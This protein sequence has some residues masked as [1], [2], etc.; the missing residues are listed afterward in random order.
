M[1]GNH[2]NSPTTQEPIPWDLAKL[3][4]APK[5]VPADGYSDPVAHAVFID[6]LPYQGRPTRFFA[7][8]AVPNAKDGKRV[9]G[10]VLVHGGGGTAH[11]RWVKQWYDRG[12]AAIAIDTSATMPALTPGE[13]LPNPQG[14]P[15]GSDHCFTQLDDPIE[16]QWAYHATANIV[17][18]HSF[19]LALPGVESERTGLTG[20]SWGGYLTCIAAGVDDRFK[21]AVPV[22]GCGYLAVDSAW[23]QR[24]D[25]MGAERR[26][27]WEK[28]WDPARYLP[29]AK[30]PMLWINGD[31]D[32][33]FSLKIF[34]MSSQL[35]QGERY[36]SIQPA[37]AHSHESGEA[38]REIAAFARQVFFKDAP[39]AQ[40]TQQGR[41]GDKAWVKFENA[42]K[43]RA[44]RLG[45][46]RDIGRWMGRKWM[47]AD[48]TWDDKSQRASCA[49]PEGTTAYYF[50]IT[51]ERGLQAS[52]EL[53]ES[54]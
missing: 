35:P 37:M 27:R 28:Y 44:V 33:A 45:F 46:T 25:D 18:S 15:K 53:C 39:L 24:F 42:G 12:F 22:Y 43:P 31:M 23:Q 16:D 38:P 48:A 32:G 30:M 20:I 21:F 19:L 17:L 13:P 2:Q 6:G 50:V 47:T 36:L 34:T 52:S 40:C 49:L 29:N 3:L 41:D 11:L 7:W 26:A 5:C 8:Y 10:M 4:I 1:A 54:K 14:G 9:P 51:D